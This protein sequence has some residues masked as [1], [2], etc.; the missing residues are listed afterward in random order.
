MS[1][2]EKV[3]QVVSAL[4]PDCGQID[5]IEYLPGGYSNDNFRVTIDDQIFVV[6]IVKEAGPRPFEKYYASLSVAPDLIAFDMSSG[7]MIT[8]WIEGSI[9]ATNSLG[10][11]EG[12]RYLRDL[13]DAI[14]SSIA[15]YDVIEQIAR[16]FE[17][18]GRPGEQGPWIE[19]IRWRE[20][21]IR[22]CHNDLNPW[23]IIRTEKSIR[24]LDWESAGDNDPLFDVIGFCY[25]AD[26]DDAEFLFCAE[27]YLGQPLRK[28]TLRKTQAIFQLREHAWAISEIG[29][30][31]DRDEII[32]Q[33]DQSIAK[34]KRLL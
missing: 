23:N 5:A 12:A 29:R 27:S 31:N 2:A 8:R 32:K 21:E 1:N 20:G 33:R 13:H 6:R 30:G 17:L 25:G 19:R 16:Y 3:I 4:M 26:Y 18:A 9:L 14:P 11:L 24:T 10:P 34:V 7:H 15:R 28:E 22:G